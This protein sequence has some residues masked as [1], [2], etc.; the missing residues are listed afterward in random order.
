MGASIDFLNQVDFVNIAQHENMLLQ[1]ANNLLATINNL[2][3]VGNAPHKVGVI[4]FVLN[5]IHPHDIAT[6]LDMEGVAVRAGHH[7]TMPLMDFYNVPAT[8]RISFA[9][10]N[11]KEEVSVLISAINKVN[12]LFKA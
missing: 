9:I 4:S 6:I 11:T 5:K 2:S 1:Y 8:T 3:I 7:C 10:Y 12:N